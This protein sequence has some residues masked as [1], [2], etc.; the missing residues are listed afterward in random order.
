MNKTILGVIIAIVLLGG[1]VLLVKNFQNNQTA[2]PQAGNPSVTVPAQT[3]VS[4][5]PTQSSATSQKDATVTIT[6]SG[7]NP[8]TI[9]VATGTKVIWINKSGTDV[10]INSNNHPTH[11]LYPPLNLGL[12]PN[13]GSV[14]LVFD[15]PGTYGY[16]NHLSP[17]QL[18]VVVVQ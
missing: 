12:V 16:H 3:S 17:D 6:A 11:L 13:G 7:F 14:S 18:A 2:L 8:Q 9:T 4:A 5:A 10:S 1:A 15:K